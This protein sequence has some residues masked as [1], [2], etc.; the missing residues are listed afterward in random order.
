M[1]QRQKLSILIR[2]DIREML[3]LPIIATCSSFI[4]NRCGRVNFRLCTLFFHHHNTFY[5]TTK[6]TTRCSVKSSITYQ[7]NIAL[8]VF[9]LFSEKAKFYA[10]HNRHSEKLLSTMMV[11]K[12]ST[13]DGNLFCRTRYKKISLKNPLLDT[14]SDHTIKNFRIYK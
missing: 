14:I 3:F 7:V 12:Q 13:K 8:I 9:F 4:P 5:Q 6:Y 1:H 11:K 10:I 2:I